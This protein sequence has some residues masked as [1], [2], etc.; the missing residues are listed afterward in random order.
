MKDPFVKKLEFSPDLNSYERAL[1]HEVAEELGGLK[2]ESVGVGKQ[3]HI[4]VEKMSTE[5]LQQPVPKETRRVSF[6]DDGWLVVQEDQ[7]QDMPS[8]LPPVDHND[9]DSQTC[10]EPA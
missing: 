5:E 9:S 6:N 2:H 10:I 3:R 4:L 7:P 1:I 8:P